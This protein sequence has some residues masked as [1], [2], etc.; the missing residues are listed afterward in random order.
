MGIMRSRHVAL[1]L[2]GLMLGLLATVAL[3]AGPASAHAA[4]VRTSP[5]QGSIVRTAPNEVVVTFSENVGLVKDKIQVIGPD[6]KRVD[7]RDPTVVGDALHIP[8]NID[9]PRGT[10]LVSYRVISADSHPVG[11]GFSYSVG[12]PSA[13]APTPTNSSSGTS[14]VVA[15]AIEVSHYV[16]YAGLILIAGTALVLSAL[17]P[18]RLNRTGPSRLAY[19]GMGLTATAAV[20]DFYLQGPYG[21]GGGLL[22]PDFT[23]VFDTTLGKALLVRLAVLALA[24]PLIPRFLAGTSGKLAR[25][26]L[27][28]LA[29]VGIGTWSLS[30]HPA[31]SSAALLTIIADAAHLTSM[32]IWVGGLVVLAVWLLRLANA[33][34]LAAILP[35]W[36]NWAALAV[37]VLVLA[38]TAQALI[39]IA[40]VDALLHTGYG[41]L[42]IAKVALLAVVLAVAAVSRRLVRR[43]AVVPHPAVVGSV[44]AVDDD[45]AYD[46]EDPDESDDESGGRE[47]GGGADETI[48]EARSE[49]IDEISYDAAGE[50]PDSG[51]V[52]R[53]AEIDR[54]ALRRLRL[55]VLIEVIG[56][57]IILGLTSVLVQTTP[58]RTAAASTASQADIGIFTETMNSPLYQLQFD[59]EPVKQGDN[60]VHLYAYTPD[61]KPLAVKEWHASAALP[62]RNI[63]PI[64][65]TLLPLTDSHATGQISLPWAGSWQFSFTLRTT[66]IDEATVTTTVVVK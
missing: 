9:V 25:S 41:Q 45:D 40:T 37:S 53:L 11:A 24:L 23:D 65:V 10:Y 13:S 52:E 34:E 19:A 8:V 31:T 56:V 54:T 49:G 3:P 12:A 17:W 55:S 5:V 48:I 4:L 35:I 61:G 30:G 27:S 47:V 50:D 29:V 38:G 59:V 64:A 44:A 43:G 16:G 18:Y 15:G 6:G 36:S 26:A 2:F 62:A 21:N 42:V 1:S 22:S 28:I 57:V 14:H 60:E 51:A 58:A 20:A 33:R 46:S 7:K 39:Q 63:E 66:D 32:A